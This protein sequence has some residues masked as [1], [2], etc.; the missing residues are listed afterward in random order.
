MPVQIAILDD[1]HVIRLTRYAIS[2]PGEITTDW[3]REFFMPEDIDPAFAASVQPGD[4]LVKVNGRYVT[5]FEPLDDVV[6]S[7]VGGQVQLEL[8]R[9]GKK[10]S[11]EEKKELFDETKATYDRQTDPR[12][13]AA[14]LWIDAIIDPLD[15]R[16]TLITAIEAASLNPEVSKF[17]VGILQT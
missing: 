16:Q 10:L 4:I 15:T 7:N 2:G 6:D 13:G 1:D 11:D 5:Q 17:S 8:E 14:R 3:A 12:Y 9:G